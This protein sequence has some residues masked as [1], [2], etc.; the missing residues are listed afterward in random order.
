MAN[1]RT[2]GAGVTECCSLLA[3]HRDSPLKMM[4][5]GSLSGKLDPLFLFRDF[6]RVGARRLPVGRRAR[7]IPLP[8]QGVAGLR[9]RA[10]RPPCRAT[11]MRLG[12]TSIGNSP[13]RGTGPKYS[14]GTTCRSA[15]QSPAIRSGCSSRSAK[16]SSR[17]STGLLAFQDAEEACET[18]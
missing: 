11:F 17:G 5:V 16:A 1:G 9:R 12:A 15:G 13:I 10:P 4:D 14:P 18:T 3:G 6:A 2:R 8:L 7:A